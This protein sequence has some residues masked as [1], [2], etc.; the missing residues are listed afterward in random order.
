MTMTLLFAPRR[1]WV[2]PGVDADYPHVF[3][4]DKVNTMTGN[5]LASVRSFLVRGLAVAAVVLTYALGSVGTHV[6]GVVGVSSLLLT[7][8]ATPAQAQRWRRY[9]Y[10]RRRRRRWRRRWW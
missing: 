10:R 2:D 8:T 1:S 3:L 4:R 6:A 5:L 9:R 7:T